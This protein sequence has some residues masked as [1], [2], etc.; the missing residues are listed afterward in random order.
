M[1]PFRNINMHTYIYIYIYYV[2]VYYIYTYILHICVLSLYIFII[3][4]GRRTWHECLVYMCSVI[5]VDGVKQFV[6]F[7]WSE[8]YG[9]GHE[10]SWRHRSSPT[11]LV[12]RRALE[13]RFSNPPSSLY[14]SMKYVEPGSTIITFQGLVH[15][16]CIV[17]LTSWYQN[18][19][20]NALKLHNGKNVYCLIINNIGKLG[21]H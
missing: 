3:Y 1:Q 18:Q 12:T 9:V 14:Y 7:P 16:L 8:G 20:I 19:E 6:S 21:V 15:H 13:E 5:I 4:K 2:Y 10:L 11:G 17:L